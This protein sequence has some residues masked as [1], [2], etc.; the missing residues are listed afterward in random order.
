MSRNP[1]AVPSALLL[2]VSVC[3]RA[4]ACVRVHAFA[5]VRMRVC[6]C[7]HACLSACACVWW[8]TMAC[9]RAIDGVGR[10]IDGVWAIDLAT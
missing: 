2:E 5:C 8:L 9:G 1:A 3:V 10:A 4:R 7:M 6:A